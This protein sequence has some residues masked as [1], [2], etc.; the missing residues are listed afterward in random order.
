VIGF[1]VIMVCRAFSLDSYWTGALC[2]LMG[3][4]GAPASIRLLEKVVITKLG[5]N[6]DADDARP[7]G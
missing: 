1:I 2:G 6:K 3:W 4:M 7:P 5:V